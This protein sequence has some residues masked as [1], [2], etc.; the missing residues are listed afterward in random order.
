MPA[1]PASFPAF[2]PYDVRKAIK[3]LERRAEHENIVSYIASMTFKPTFVVLVDSLIAE[4]REAAR[5]SLMRQIYTDVILVDTLDATATAASSD[6]ATAKYLIW[7]D[8]GDVLDDYALFEL[9]A[10]LNADSQTDLIYFDSEAVDKFGKSNPF[11]KPDW[12]PDYLESHDYI[13]SAAC[14]KLGTAARF[15]TDVNS[16][17]DLTLRVTESCPTVRHIALCL[18]SHPEVERLPTQRAPADMQAI[19]RRLSRTRRTA[20]I[21]EIGHGTGA[22]DLQVELRTRPL[23]SAVIPTAGRV[24]QYNGKRID[25]IVDCIDAIVNTSTY[26]NIEFIVID[27]GDFDRDRL[28]HVYDASI[29][30]LTY[31]LSE[32]NIAKKINLG[33]SAASGEVI[34]ILNDDIEPLAADWIE[35]MLGHLEKPHVGVVGAK[36]LYPDSTIQHAGVVA[37]SGLPQHVRRGMPRNDSGYHFSTSAVRNYAAV[38]GAVSM[39]PADLFHDVGGY[40]ED[41]PINFNDVD[42]CYKIIAAGYSVVYE[43]RAELTHYESVSVAKPQQTAEADRFLRTWASCV[44]DPFYNRRCFDKHPPTYAPLYSEPRY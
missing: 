34:L 26:K 9:A 41:F 17:Y 12:S 33:A 8:P 30:F 42:F 29:K 1:D 19:T 38:T 21:S 39:V 16:R 11:H 25:L 44:E 5:V 36:L 43:P 10:E 7:L 3:L 27:N 6:P 32:V 23:V 22:Y 40:S 24:I 20:T 13:G 31:S 37:C 15:L 14:F 4:E 28:E 35:R 18:L 2:S